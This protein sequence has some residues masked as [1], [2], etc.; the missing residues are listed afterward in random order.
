[1][2]GAN[3]EFLSEMQNKYPQN[4]NNCKVLEIGSC[5]DWNGQPAVFRKYFS[6]CKYI[7]IDLINGTGVDIIVK[8]QETN[9]PE[10]YFD[11]MICFSV[12][13]HEP[14]WRTIISHNLP[15][16]K[17]NSMLFL[18]WGA[19]GNPRHPP[20]PWAIVSEQEFLSYIKTLPIKVIES[21]FE[22]TRYKGYVGGAYDA[23]LKVL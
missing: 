1:M 13:E 2:H 11:T 7:G 8:A 14:D 3:F 19:E 17:N 22:Q 6:N 5:T 10:K 16:M 20:E 15:F 23:V 21:F 12:F 18:A 9:F 4:F